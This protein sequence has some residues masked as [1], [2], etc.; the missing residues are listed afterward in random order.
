M[1]EELIVGWW[2]MLI[3]WYEDV[4]G[5]FLFTNMMIWCMLEDFFCLKIWWYD[6]CWS[7]DACWYDDMK[8]LFG[9]NTLKMNVGGFFCDMMHVGGFVFIDMS[10]VDMIWSIMCSRY[11]WR[12]F[13]W[14]DAWWYDF[15]MMHVYVC[16]CLWCFCLWNFI[17]AATSCG[18]HWPTVLHAGLGIRQGSSCLFHRERRGKWYE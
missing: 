14:Y 8:M 13:L 16:L 9:D 7:D 15:D 10:N 1:W 4:G 2:C 12:I 6:A 3:W 18:Q 11:C 5:I 17:K